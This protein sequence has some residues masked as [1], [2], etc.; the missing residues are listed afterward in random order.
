MMGMRAPLV[1]IACTIATMPDDA[2]AANWPAGTQMSDWLAPQHREGHGRRVIQQ[3]EQ[4]LRRTAWSALAL[5]P[6]AHRLDW[7]P[8]TGGELGLRQPCLRADA[9]GISGI[10][11]RWPAGLDRRRQD[12]VVG[13]GGHRRQRALAAITEDFDQTPVGLQSHPH[14]RSLLW[15]RGRAMD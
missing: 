3:L 8:N 12:A 4:C 13:I 14:H 1:S 5:L 15:V 6:I 11:L 9:A 2:D 7:H 10:D